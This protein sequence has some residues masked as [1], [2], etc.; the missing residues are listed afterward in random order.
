MSSDVKLLFETSKSEKLLLVIGTSRLA[1]FNS[2][3]FLKTIPVSCANP[4]NKFGAQIAELIASLSQ[5]I[6]IGTNSGKHH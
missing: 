4:E 2:S 3:F 5:Y 6:P 1:M